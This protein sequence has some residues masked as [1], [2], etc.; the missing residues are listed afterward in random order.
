MYS[1]NSNCKY[2]KLEDLIKITKICSNLFNVKF[3][4]ISLYDLSIEKI[5][6][7]NSSSLRHNYPTD[8]ITFSY[9]IKKFKD[10]EI[11]FSSE[12]LKSDLKEGENF[13]TE[14]YRLYIHG[15]LHAAGF[16]D[17]TFEEKEKMTSFENLILKQFFNVSRETLKNGT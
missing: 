6:E 16:N 12:Y 8:V 2:F 13:K 15:L 3:R 7:L 5:I 14:L 10:V 11:Y 4:K 1:I 17:H 9:T